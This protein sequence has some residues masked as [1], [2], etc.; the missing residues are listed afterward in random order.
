MTAN[1]TH[2]PLC[3]G[4]PLSLSNPYAKETYLQETH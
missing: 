1:E 4:V 2:L 3:Q